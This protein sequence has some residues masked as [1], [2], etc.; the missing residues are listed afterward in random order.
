MRAG[1]HD[2]NISCHAA[3]NHG[4]SR[5]IGAAQIG[6]PPGARTRNPRI[7]RMR[8]TDDSPC[9]LR[10]CCSSARRTALQLPP[11][12]PVRVT[13]RV[14]TGCPTRANP[15]R[16]GR[17]RTDSLDHASGG[18]AYA[19]GE[20]LPERLHLRVPALHPAWSSPRLT[21]ICRSFATGPSADLFT[22]RVFRDN[23]AG[24]WNQQPRDWRPVVVRDRWTFVHWDADVSRR[25]SAARTDSTL[26]L[27]D[28]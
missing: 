26:A 28:R 18:F 27:P 11:W 15:T 22:G 16:A 9:C 25:R 20:A 24:A 13:T 12:A 1:G 10:L 8:H 7:K 5:G 19:S 23:S 6:R 2:T 17:A 14:T 21:E 3:E 4:H